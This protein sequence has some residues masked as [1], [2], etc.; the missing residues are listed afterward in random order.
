MPFSPDAQV[1]DRVLCTKLSRVVAA[2]LPVATPLRSISTMPTSSRLRSSC[3][4]E[5]PFW[6]R[7]THILSFD[8]PSSSAVSLP[9]PLVS[10]ACRPSRSVLAPSRSWTNEIS[11]RLLI[12]PSP[13][14]SK[15][16]MPLVG[17]TQEVRAYCPE[18]RRDTTIED[19]TPVN[20]RPSPP[21]SKT[22]GMTPPL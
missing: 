13:L 2:V 8:H 4:V 14:R 17:P 12:C 3:A 9:S 18:D 16:R 10:Q 20:S 6:L 15:A 11:A 1:N 5:R 22:I 7:S 21:R 19:S